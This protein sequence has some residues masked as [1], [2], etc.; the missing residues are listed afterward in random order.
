[1]MA[2]ASAGVVGVIMLIAGLLLSF[3]SHSIIGLGTG[4]VE[5]ITIYDSLIGPGLILVAI[6][7]FRDHDAQIRS[8]WA[9]QI[10][11]LV[12]LVLS[13][14]LSQRLGDA[15]WSLVVLA[16]VCWLAGMFMESRKLNRRT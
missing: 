13:L 8:L 10:V 4:F 14:M 6:A 7:S 3:Q 11:C 1:M 5:R 12:G 2:T 16:L 15:A 9:W